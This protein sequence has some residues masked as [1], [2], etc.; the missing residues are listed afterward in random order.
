MKVWRFATSEKSVRAWF[1]NLV[2]ALSAAWNWSAPFCA[3]ISFVATHPRPEVVR[4]RLPG[5]EA[6]VGL[7]QDLLAANALGEAD[8]DHAS[9]FSAERA[10]VLGMGVVGA[11]AD[12]DGDRFRVRNAWR[13]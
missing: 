6:G 2:D 5:H 10:A 1:W 8:V 7:L 13:F 9:G 11:G 3:V 4:A 12:L